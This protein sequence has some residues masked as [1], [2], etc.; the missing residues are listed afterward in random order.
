MVV[1]PRRA[2]AAAFDSVL[3]VPITVAPASC[4]ASVRHKSQGDLKNHSSCARRSVVCRRGRRDPARAGSCERAE[5]AGGGCA[6]SVVR[7]ISMRRTRARMSSAAAVVRD[8]GARVRGVSS[9]T[10]RTPAAHLGQRALIRTSGRTRPGQWAR[11]R[12]TARARRPARKSK[13]ETHVQSLPVPSCD[14]DARGP[15]RAAS[16]CAHV[17]T[18][19]TRPEARGR[20]TAR[21]RRPGTVKFGPKRTSR[22]CPRRDLAQHAALDAARC[23]VNLLVE[24]RRL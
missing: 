6:R 4:T 13:A 19:A 22:A 16:T 14:A 10:M 1:Q 8:A 5:C 7:Y 18:R 9:A 15:P 12:R 23:R 21:A 24:A 17:R 3:V 2:S 11:G 20:R